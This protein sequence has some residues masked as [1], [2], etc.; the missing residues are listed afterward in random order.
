MWNGHCKED[1]GTGRS[2]SRDRK[3]GAVL[4]RQD[5]D[6]S[7]SDS[8]VASVV[9]G[10]L[11]GERFCGIMKVTDDPHGTFVRRKASMPEG[12]KEERSMER[13]DNKGRILRKGESQRA[14]GRYDYRYVDKLTG[15]RQSFYANTLV[16]LREKERKLR[17]DREDGIFTDTESRNLTVNTL[18]ER[19]MSLIEIAPA[20]EKNYRSLWNK[21]ARDD[22]GNMKV[23]EVKQSHVRAVYSRMSKAGYAKSTIQLLRTMLYPALELAVNDDLIRKNPAK[24]AFLDYGRAPVK[25]K[26]LT[27]DQQQRLLQ[28]AEES[29][30]YRVHV[31]LLQVMLGTA[32]RCG[33]IIGLTWS[34][35]DFENGHIT[36]DHQLT[37]KD[38]GDGWKFHRREPKTEA[39]KRTIPM[40]EEVREAL[41]EQRKNQLAT[42]TSSNVEIDGLR[43]FVFTTRNGRPVMPSDINNILKNLV[44]G[45]NALERKTAKNEFRKPALIP[46][47][48][49]HILRHT[50]CTRLSEKGM[51]PKVLQYLM[52]HAD[53]TVTMNVYNHIADLSHVE[54]EV[55]RVEKTG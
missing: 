53:I 23:T 29:R 54:D 24:G 2:Q 5:R 38:Y 45:Y 19:Y 31:P 20:T 48:S 49:A 14:D 26:A 12:G 33:E 18:F 51:N 8:D 27:A 15:K 42:G 50:G 6:L 46:H 43:N 32:C 34:D 41:I 44:D 37:Y 10:L 4:R 25:R 7:E 21:H 35:V 52:G 30:F 16:E 11:P 17:R 40:T 9:A 55:K 3:A 36:I 13:K 28:F 22:L 39:G 47:I 1:R